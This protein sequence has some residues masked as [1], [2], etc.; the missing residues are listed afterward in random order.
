[1]DF[2]FRFNVYVDT[3]VG[4]GSPMNAA[5][6]PSSRDN[7]FT[8]SLLSFISSL[9]TGVE[10]VNDTFLT[11]AFV[12]ISSP[13]SLVDDASAVTNSN[14]PPGIPARMARTESATAVRGVRSLG[15]RTTVHPAASA[16]PAFLVIMAM[17]KFHGVIS[18]HTPTASLIARILPRGA[19]V[20]GCAKGVGQMVPPPAEFGRNASAA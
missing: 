5:L 13:T 20:P 17:G 18:P 1:M 14:T 19:H 7:R 3:A 15:F 16:G 8:V 12:H 6:P 10:P 4:G 9:P 2:L 11:T